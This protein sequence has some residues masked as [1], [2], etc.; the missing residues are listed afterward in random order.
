MEGQKIYTV[1]V[2]QTPAFLWWCWQTWQ[3]KN[4]IIMMAVYTFS[5]WYE[6]V[7]RY[8][9]SWRNEKS[10]YAGDVLF[11]NKLYKRGVTAVVKKYVKKICSVIFPLLFTLLISAAYLD[12][13]IL[14]SNVFFSISIFGILFFFGILPIIL[15]LYIDMS[16]LFLMR[17]ISIPIFIVLV[18]LSLFYFSSFLGTFC[19]LLV[20]IYC[21]II[22]PYFFKPTAPTGHPTL[23]LLAVI[24]SDPILHLSIIILLHIIFPHQTATSI[25]G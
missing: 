17:L 13:R 11:S 7:R 2:E 15:T 1:T 19:V 16:S 14:S 25:P 20:I 6:G 12:K 8:T 24:T 10:T 21:I 18:T 3:V 4:V 9:Q 23:E 22:E 5:Y